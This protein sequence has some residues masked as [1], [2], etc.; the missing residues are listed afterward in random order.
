M[1]PILRA[2][3][4]LLTING[5]AV[6]SAGKA[7][8]SSFSLLDAIAARWALSV[9]ATITSFSADPV[10][11]VIVDMRQPR[12]RYGPPPDEL[13]LRR[14]SPPTHVHCPAFTLV[15]GSA[16]ESAS[17][18]PVVAVS[19]ARRLP[20]ALRTSPSSR[21]RRSLPS[22]ADTR[23]CNLTRTS[24]LSGMPATRSQLCRAF[25]RQ[26]GPSRTGSPARLRRIPQGRR[27][28]AARKPN[29]AVKGRS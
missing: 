22:C 12:L 19:H 1:S 25:D 23:P 29:A 14:R 9:R 4:R 27:S 18:P 28:A 21:P 8:S 2:T 10:A 7:S 6:E 15:P 13:A 20:W 26:I 3:T 17:E 5:C 11:P 16:I 24:S